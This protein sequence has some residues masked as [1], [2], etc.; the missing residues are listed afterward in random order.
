MFE[1]DQVVKTKV[2]RD[3]HVR[4]SGSDVKNI[5]INHRKK[6]KF[7]TK[8]AGFLQFQINVHTSI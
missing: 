4:S 5:V 7:T 6:L 3:K 8:T 2:T 1:Q